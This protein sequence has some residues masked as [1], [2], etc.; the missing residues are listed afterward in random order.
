MSFAHKEF[1]P[2][3]EAPL[4]TPVFS[5]RREVLVGRVA[6]AGFYASCMWESF[7]MGLGPISQLSVITGLPK[8]VLQGVLLGFMLHGLWGLLPFTPTWSKANRK[9]LALR[10]KGFPRA[11]INPVNNPEE[12]FGY[13]RWGF[14]KRNEVF[15]GRIAML[16]FVG[17]CMAEAA[18]GGRGALG[19]VA[20]WLHL[21]ISPTY[22][23]LC[24]VLLIGTPVVFGVLAYVKG[25]PGELKGGD[26]IY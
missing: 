11:L 16:G 5:R 23:Q 20:W 26:D 19:Q 15:A 18:S 21:P 3:F 22:Y 13:S 14:T 25:R 7:L 9:D 24:N 2:A 12:F 8:L 1:P 17:T 4:N 6:M 10:P